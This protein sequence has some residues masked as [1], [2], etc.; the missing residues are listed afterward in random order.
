MIEFNDNLQISTG[1]L[2]SNNFGVYFCLIK[3]QF[4]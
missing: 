1:I 4:E 3:N 2:K